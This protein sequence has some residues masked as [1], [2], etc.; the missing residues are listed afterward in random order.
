MLWET[1]PV[2]LKIII[3]LSINIPNFAAVLFGSGVTMQFCQ[4]IPKKENLSIVMVEI[5]EML[6]TTVI[7]VWMD[8]LDLIENHIQA[9]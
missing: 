7:S 3:I 6:L 5:L 8:W 4:D 1:V 2:T 9:F